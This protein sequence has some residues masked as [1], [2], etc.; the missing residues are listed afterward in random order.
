M[1]AEYLFPTMLHGLSGGVLPG[2]C[3]PCLLAD[4]LTDQATGPALCNYAAGMPKKDWPG[5]VKKPGAAK[6]V[7]MLP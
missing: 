4:S 6:F 5:F 3:G 1:V 7:T 2:M